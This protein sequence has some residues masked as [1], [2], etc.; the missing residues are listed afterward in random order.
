MCIRY[1]CSP[2][3]CEYLNV[4]VPINSVVFVT[5]GWHLFNIHTV[6]RVWTLLSNFHVGR[7]T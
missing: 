3:V 6:D 7:L 2:H 1:K 4:P 5:N